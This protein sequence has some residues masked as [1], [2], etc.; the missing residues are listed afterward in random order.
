[1]SSSYA[2]E[3]RMFAG[4]FA[5]VYWAFCD[6]SLLPI[7]EYDLLFTLIGTTY[8]GDG[9][10]TFALPD[11]RGRVPVHA[12]TGTDGIG[13]IIGE[14][15]GVE[16]VTLTKQTMAIHDHQYYASTNTAGS[17]NAANQVLGATQ[18]VQIYNAAGV[19]GPPMDDRAVAPAGGGQAHDN[20]MP[21]LAI[22][23]IISLYGIYPPP[24]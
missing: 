1:M 10:S 15:G 14:L 24:G 22:G 2:G 7:A 5:P 13:Y 12:G 6:G 9:Q 19:V 23:F 3:I 8:G 11:L 18:S 4:N 20:S 16:T 21:S 17:P